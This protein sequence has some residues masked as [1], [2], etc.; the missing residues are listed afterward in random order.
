MA[1]FFD[2]KLSI[3][4]PHKLFIGG[5]WVEPASDKRLELMSPVT[6]QATGTVAEAVEADVDRAVAAAREAFDRGPWP[7]MSPAERGVYLGRLSE[8]LK[9]RAEEL[10]HA[11]SGQI[12]TLFPF[13]QA[14]TMATI[15]M[16]DQWVQHAPNYVWQEERPSSIPGHVSIKISEP[17]GVVATIAPWNGPFFGIGIKVV[18]ALLAGCTVVMK[19]S[20]ETPLEAYIISECIEAAGF[21]PGVVN[22]VPADREVSDYLVRQP[23]IDKVSFTGS[24]AVG[25]RIASVCGERVARVTLELGGKS[26]AIVL[27]DADIDQVTSIL[28]PTVTMA[29]GQF[30]GNVTRHLISRKR[31]DGYVEALAAKLKTIQVGDPYD[32]ASQMGP[33]AMKRQFDRVAGYIDK[34]LAEG[35]RLITGGGRPAGFDRGYYFEPTLFANVDNRSKIAQEEIFGPVICAI[36]YDDVDDAIRIAN[37]SRYGLV[38]AVFTQDTDLAYH[39]AR[40]VRTGSMSQNSLLTDFALGY[41]GFKE[42]G[43]GREGGVDAVLPYLETKGVVLTAMPSKL[44]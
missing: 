38:G 11:W 8:K 9:E 20:P 37:D 26:A 35:A 43:L 2:G 44:D 17:V 41:G 30:C 12:G 14:L 3:R 32:P 23:D 33:L 10:A 42:S 29:C 7:R 1:E 25:K 34:G 6:E 39:V 15:G 13:A 24:T 36:P 40:S 18:P 4:Y 5:Q 21:P 16:I 22:L 19:P 27:D 28:A 31:Y